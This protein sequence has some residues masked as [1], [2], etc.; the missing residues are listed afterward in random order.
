[1][2]DLKLLTKLPFGLL[3][4]GL[5]PVASLAKAVSSQQAG[6]Q[7]SRI[8]KASRVATSLLSSSAFHPEPAE[9]AARKR[10]STGRPGAGGALQTP[11]VTHL[12]EGCGQFSL[13][14]HPLLFL[15]IVHNPCIC[16]TCSPSKLVG[17]VVCSHC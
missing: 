16:F 5:T 12:L 1:M 3:M 17:P 14:F 10:G 8:H 7:Q 6:Y 2:Y 4:K 9:T 15:I 11:S 13:V